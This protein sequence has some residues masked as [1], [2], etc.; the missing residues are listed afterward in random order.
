MNNK[1]IISILVALLIQSVAMSQETIQ[2]NNFVGGTASLNFRKYKF[3]NKKRNN[4]E[5]RIQPVFGRNLNKNF[6][7]GGGFYLG[8]RGGSG[9]LDI[10]YFSREIGIHGLTR[11]RYFLGEKTAIGASASLLVTKM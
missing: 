2:K 1:L 6:A 10:E 8:M 5:L 4:S 9:Y 3:D 7:V 11:Y